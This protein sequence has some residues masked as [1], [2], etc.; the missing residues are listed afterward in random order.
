MMRGSTD[1]KL[2]H[3]QI[4]PQKWYKWDFDITSDQS[5][6]ASVDVRTFSPGAELRIAG[7]AFRMYRESPFRGAFIL[8]SRGTELARAIKPS[9]MKRR[10][11]VSFAGQAYELTASSALGRKFT[12]RDG[13]EVIGEITPRGMLTRK[14]DGYLSEHLPTAIQVFVIALVLFMWKRQSD[15][16]SAG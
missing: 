14:A 9:A 16:S 12:L 8:E 10:F 13:D 5:V 15:S 11:E 6:V 4:L 1:K 7:E 2:E 3:F